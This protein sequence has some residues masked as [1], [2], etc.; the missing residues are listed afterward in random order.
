MKKLILPIIVLFILLLVSPSSIYAQGAVNLNGTW[1]WEGNSFTGQTTGSSISIIG[2]NGRGFKG[3]VTGNII[4]GKEYLVSDKCPNL[5]HDSP[6]TGVISADG[7]SITVTFIN[8]TYSLDECV[9][10]PNTDFEDTHAYTRASAQNSP[11]AQPSPSL[12]PTDTPLNLNG[13]WT[14]VNEKGTS[15]TFNG[16]HTGNSLSL[17]I[18]D[19]SDDIIKDSI[20]K[21]SLSGTLSGH[22]FSG[23]Q[24]LIPYAPKCLGKYFNTDGT[25]TVAADG[26]SITISFT[27]FRYDTDTC[28]KISGTEFQGSVT[29]V[30]AN[31][32]QN[33][34]PGKDV[35]QAIPTPEITRIA[36][37]PS[38]GVS[39]KDF[40][41]L[42]RANAEYQKAQAELEEVKKASDPRY[43]AKKDF[44][45]NYDAA[46]KGNEKQKEELAVLRADLET[47]HELV[48][49][50]KDFSEIEETVE[51]IKKGEI[52]NYGKMD[53]FTDAVKSFNDYHDLR[54][55]GVSVKDAA[56]KSTLDNFGSSVLTLIPV[57]KAIDLVATTPDFILGVFGVS[58]NNWSRAYVTNGFIG[59]FA[60]SGV[61]KQ[62]TDLMIEDDWADIGNAL[63]YGW[64]KVQAADGIVETAKES[65]KLLAAT[66]G[67][68]PVAIA[69]GVSDIV[70]GG[71]AAAEGVVDLIR[72]W[73]T[74]PN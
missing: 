52:G 43:E 24:I 54:S 18:T 38:V 39:S 26:S 42:A 3:T 45:S 71:I 7:N 74:W 65:G 9:D 25:G 33:P 35:E 49:K 73:F 21:T 29:Y 13:A 14:T 8:N 6:A 36:E 57:L 11:T 17:Q 28:A 50:Y 55:S 20:G 62:T 15:F 70:G 61:V 34:T 59:K 30:R 44:A 66:V 5:N 47:I 72:S 4:K 41:A 68:V 60:P 37:E 31:K 64:G 23:T 46:F 2:N 56:T 40:K 51:S 1:L 32:G 12:T 58:E 19:A 48:S 27:N 16:R 67:A 69:Q 10:K 53:F 22:E 63:A